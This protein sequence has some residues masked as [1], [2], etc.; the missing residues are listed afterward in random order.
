M[1]INNEDSTILYRY[2]YF[3]TFIATLIARSCLYV[4]T[5][6]KLLALSVGISYLYVGR[7]LFE[8]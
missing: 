8:T 2:H 3:C 7:D 1:F 6:G 5:A 4:F